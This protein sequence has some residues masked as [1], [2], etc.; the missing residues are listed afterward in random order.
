[1]PRE[2]AGKREAFLLPRPGHRAL[3]LVVLVAVLFAIAVSIAGDVE[4]LARSLDSVLQSPAS[5]ALDV[6]SDEDS[7]NTGHA[8]NSR[9]IVLREDT[10][11]LHIPDTGVN[12]SQTAYGTCLTRSPPSA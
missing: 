2:L 4:F 1:M 8:R 10:D 12:L 7:F 9:Q 5:H 3:S 11:K 6:F